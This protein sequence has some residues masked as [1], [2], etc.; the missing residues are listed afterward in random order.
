MKILKTL[1]GTLAT[2]TVLCNVLP[3][4]ATETENHNFRLLPAPK[5]I[6]VDGKA[7]DWNLAGGIFASNDV[8]T[9]RDEYA[10]W[11]H[12]AYDSENLYILA[13]FNDLAP[14][15]NPNDTKLEF[16]WEG[17][18]V[19]VRVITN[20]GK[21]NQQVSVANCW[22]GHDRRDVVELDT[23]GFTKNTPK[24]DDIKP[25]GAQQAFTVNADNRG[26]VQEIAIPWK[27]LT[28]GEAPK[29][30]D[31]IGITFEPNFTTGTHNR[32][33]TKDVFKPGVPLDRVFTFMNQSVWGTATLL[34]D[35]NIQPVPVRLSD[36]RTFPV[37]MQGGVPIVDW[38]GLVKSNEL[39]GFVPVRFTMPE[40][41]RISIVIKNKEGAIVR[42]LLKNAPFGKGEHTVMWDG[43]ANPR[44]RSP[45]KPVEVGDYSWSGIWHKDIGLKWRGFAANAGIVP[46]D[47]GQ[48]TNWGGDMG[49][50]DSAASEG[51]YVLLGWHSS[52]AGKAAVLCDLNGK[53]IWSHKRGGFG[54]A[55]FVGLDGG[56]AFILDHTTLYK[57]GAADSNVVAFDGGVGEKSWNSMIGE[58]ELPWTPQGFAVKNGRMYFS[59]SNYSFRTSD[60]AEWR[61]F[62]TQISSGTDDPVW[63]KVKPSSQKRIADW[64]KTNSAVNDLG[65]THNQS[66][67]RG[68]VIEA[69]NK[70]LAE[71]PETS[72]LV[73]G[74]LRAANS[75]ALQKAYGLK[76]RNTGFVAV[77][78]AKS[79]KMERKIPL[80]GAGDLAAV[81]NGAYTIV[82]GTSVVFVDAATGAMKTVI[83]GL[84]GAHSVALDAAGNF[85]IATRAPLNQVLV[86]STK[87]KLLRSIGKKGGRAA[88]GIWDASALRDISAVAVDREGKL[89]VGESVDLPKRF[90]TWD[91]RTGKLIKEYF[92]ATRYGASGGAISLDDPNVM[93]GESCEWKLD[94]KTGSASIVGVIDTEAHA[95]ARFAKGANGR[96]YLAVA[97]PSYIGTGLYAQQG[98]KIFER[99]KAGQYK[100]RST[101]FVRG[102]NM[103]DGRGTQTEFWADANDDQ[104]P[105]PAELS[106]L[107]RGSRI[108]GYYLWSMYLNP[109]LTF[110]GGPPND[111]KAHGDIVRVKSFTASGAPVYDVTNA[112]TSPAPFGGLASLD[113]E[114]LLT[115]GA[116]EGGSVN[117][118]DLSSG[119]TL[120]TYANGWSGVHG[121][122]SAP[123]PEPGLLRGVLGVVGTAKLPEPLGDIWALNSNVGEWHLLTRDGYYL[124][125]LFNG[126]QLKVKFPDKATPGTDVSE[127]P[128]G[129]GGEDFG[130]S[131]MQGKDGKVYIQSG[132]TALWN[133]EV[134]GLDTV[135]ALGNGALTI[136][137]KDVLTAGALR[138]TLLQEVAGPKTVAARKLSPTF[139]G[140]LDTDFKG[141]VITPFQKSDDAKVRSAIA[142]DD[143]NL[144][145]GW[146]VA[147][148]TPWTNAAKA[149]EDLYLS[150]D[151]VDF[152]LGTN[153]AADKNRNDAIAGDLRLSIGNF[154][155][156]NT[157]VIYR[158]VSAEK[159]P[160][161][162]S[163]GIVREY[164]MDYVSV[165]NEAKITVTKRDGGYLVEAAIPWTALG[166]TP[167]AGLSLRGDFGVTHGDPAGTRTRLRTYWSNQVT[168][169]V[170][171]AVYELMITPANWGTIVLK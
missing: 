100:L 21:P 133:L 123:Q 158:K 91:T 128:P 146:D 61:G 37:A 164:P 150:G 5:D 89:W 171:D 96:E 77:V 129:L 95:F 90:S 36:R 34:P 148:N 50:P 85:Y 106:T 99:L 109:D 54:G 80:V 35:D 138:E 92:G 25:L 58:P 30:G 76:V 121:S 93:V 98:I 15:N 49:P 3:A 12:G 51:N 110:Y 134:T 75:A 72:K 45:N 156:Q 112:K 101:I 78:D 39:R 22:K 132:K 118:Y 139:T 66:D 59:S 13:R 53:P 68:D 4:A 141:A 131:M 130:G 144:Y 103:A 86:Y 104:K 70:V 120:W 116:S 73:G 18:S 166:T 159:K 1:T 151:T 31:S 7:G 143:A 56:V 79:G 115:G 57:L 64:L 169:I 32:L 52:E 160:K 147:D 81:A 149:P 40:G 44:W 67:A 43:L 152:Q 114:V 163:S 167:K 145:L 126:D 170:D 162:F 97:V 20:A 161:I 24:G 127:I 62:L 107:P 48:G 111:S 74:S 94:P 33:S 65:K 88:T 136:G 125:R 38:T 55:P 165:L 84:V 82:D 71:K 135:K 119:K 102:G 8:E 16:G 137:E 87:G 122:H 29:A 46:W 142:Y 105:Q 42:H 6:K 83:K 108:G 47:N 26:Y 155:G 157:A 27:F 140:N 41:G 168:G 60:V 2:A 153:E 19:Q 23:P 28:K 113:G 17:D 117:L 154:G 69:L 11:L 10:V 14:L 63:Q 124:S 9:V